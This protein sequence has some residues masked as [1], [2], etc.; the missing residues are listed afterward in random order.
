[1]LYALFSSVIKPPNQ[2]SSDREYISFYQL[3]ADK[4]VK[5]K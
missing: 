4:K 3:P 1:M 5:L 2:K